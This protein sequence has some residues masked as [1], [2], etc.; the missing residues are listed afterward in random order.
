VYV[1]VQADLS[2][3]VGEHPVARD[4]LAA[5]LKAATHMTADSASSCAPIPMCL[6]AN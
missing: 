3:R 2:L 5:A 1:T 6:T 4:G